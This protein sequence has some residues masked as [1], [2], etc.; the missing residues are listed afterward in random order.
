M[1]RRSCSLLASGLLSTN[2]ES[3]KTEPGGGRL[4]LGSVILWSV[5]IYVVAGAE[6]RSLLTPRTLRTALR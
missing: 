1:I 2:T 6:L 3:R 5:S 4:S